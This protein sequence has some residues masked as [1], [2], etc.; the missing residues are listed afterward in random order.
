MPLDYTNTD[1]SDA[2]L[3]TQLL[4]ALNGTYWESGWAASAGGGAMEVD[5]DSGSGY[6]S[7]SSVSTGGTQTVTISSN[8]SGSPR[9]DVIYVDSGGAV[10]V[11]EGTPAS[12]L[13]S[14][15][16]NEQTY[17]PAP[18]DGSAFTGVVVAEVWV[19]DGATDIPSGDIR[20]RRVQNIVVTD[21]ANLSNVQ[22]DQH[23]TRPTT[24]QSDTTG[25][26]GIV[27]NQNINNQL[28]ICT[29]CVQVKGD[30]GSV[31]YS[32]SDNTTLNVSDGSTVTVDEFV[33]SGD[34]GDTMSD[35][36][37]EPANFPHSHSI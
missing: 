26:G 36:A 1:G 6:V 14:G 22:S 33:M 35:V 13:P 16:T 23:H 24:T 31:D 19:P 32:M 25:T 34:D 15:A 10:A 7:D 27:S 17:Q 28:G 37:I 8:A 9:K 29:Y 3:A 4:D 21:H 2:L 30:G 20:D 5:V 12:A 11:A 18:P